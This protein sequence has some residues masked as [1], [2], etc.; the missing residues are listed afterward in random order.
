MEASIILQKTGTFNRFHKNNGRKA[1][2]LGILGADFGSLVT[3]EPRSVAHLPQA[4]LGG[5]P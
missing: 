2:F 5:F 3:P 4:N 1:L